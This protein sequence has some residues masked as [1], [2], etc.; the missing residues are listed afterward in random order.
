MAELS[1]EEL[2]KLNTLFGEWGLTA[3]FTSTEDLKKMVTEKQ[4]IKQEPKKEMRKEPDVDPDHHYKEHRPRLSVF[5]GQKDGVAYEVWRYEV[6]CHLNNRIPVDLIMDAIRRSVKGDVAKVI[7]RLGARADVTEVIH[8]LDGLYGKVM[9]EGASLTLFYATEQKEG[10]DVTAWSCRLE[11][12]I[13]P[14]EEKGLIDKRTKDEMLRSKL[15]NG[16]KD[17]RLKQA[18]RYK[19]DTQKNYDELVIAIRA[20]EQELLPIEES[21]GEKKV[22]THVIQTS[23]EK[24][25]KTRLIG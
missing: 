15:W 3:G 17:D 24:V 23:T 25:D 14:A 2:T 7:M 20:V 22:K 12:L 8:K 5:S 21:K 13:Q 10:E 18:T 6:T 1:E 11:D 4:Q 19:F 9:S 16:L